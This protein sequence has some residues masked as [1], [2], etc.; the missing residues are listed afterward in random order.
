M[1]IEIHIHN[2]KSQLVPL[3]PDGNKTKFPKQTLPT[4]REVEHPIVNA[5]DK[6]LRYEIETLIQGRLQKVPVKR[7]STKTYKFDTGCLSYVT[8]VLKT[9]QQ[10]YT[11]VDKRIP[12]PPGEVIP[13]RKGVKVRPYQEEATK[14]A[15]KSQRGVLRLATG[16][17]KTFIA[18]NVLRKLNVPT[19]IFVHTIDLLD[20]FKEAGEFFLNTP[21]GSIGNGEV[22]IQQFTVCMMQTVCKAFDQK[23]VSYE[24]DPEGDYAE[25]SK[26]YSLQQ[27]MKIR[28]LVENAQAIVSDEC[29]VKG[30]PIIDGN[31]IPLPIEEVTKG[32]RV[33]SWNFANQHHEPQEVLGLL[34][35]TTNS[36][37]KIKSS[38]G[39]YETTPTHQWYVYDGIQKKIVKK[40]SSELDSENDRLLAPRKLSHTVLNN[41]S[42]QQAEFLALICCDG[43]SDSRSNSIK[44]EASKDVEYF[45]RAFASYRSLNEEAREHKERVSKRSNENSEWADTTV[46]DL[47][48]A[49]VRQQLNA[50]GIP[51]GNK[52][53]IVS[54]PKQI[55]NAPLPTV[56]QFLNTTYC[57][58]GSVQG[59]SIDLRMTSKRYVQEIQLLLMRFGIIAH[60]KEFLP[61]KWK[62][63]QE[64]NASKQYHLAICDRAS[65]ELFHQHVGFNIARKHEK[66]AQLVASYTKRSRE[67]IPAYGLLRAYLKEIGVSTS[68]LWS[69]HRIPIPSKGTVRLDMVSR[70]IVREVLRLTCLQ[71]EQ[72]SLY[73]ELLERTRYYYNKILEIEEREE[74]TEVYD[75]EVA[76][77]HTFFAGTVITSNCHHLSCKTLQ[78]LFKCAKNAFYRFGL[79]AT[80]REDGADLVIYGVTGRVVYDVTA[81]Y[82]IEH[83]PPYLVR[84]TIYYLKVKRPRGSSGNYHSRYKSDIVE[85]DVRNELIIQS[86]MRLVRKGHRVL[87]LARQIKH[88][89]LLRDMME[90]GY[91]A[92]WD[93]IKDMDSTQIKYELAT[94]AVNKKER[95]RIVSEMRRGELECLFA[96]TIA[97]EG[98]DC[99]PISAVILAGGGKSATKAFQRVGRALRLSEGKEKAVII[100]FYDQGKYF[101]KHAER[102]M[103][104]FKKEPAFRLKIQK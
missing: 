69:K 54:V 60:Y 80:L 83:N 78:T 101:K 7:F 56:A 98:L 52:H 18:W 39:I 67:S 16:A 49:Q 40:A 51:S 26:E 3:L 103:E 41:L 99:P 46:W 22:D 57:C 65:I 44:V 5:L 94:G 1:N 55:F 21:V 53:S 14:A 45:R 88:L 42:P 30:T 66:V 59:R 77:T 96:S 68:S 33:A 10:P 73:Q 61:S 95:K 35:R 6:E 48:D 62:R 25:D 86:A 104:L 63:K 13:F 19:V 24:V 81:S 32:S 76:N 97:D 43:H 89:K 87:V 50:F 93:D 34:K 31:G 27:K 12:T 74:E 15:L 2:I 58:E 85:Y 82:L 84:P 91:G 71:G 4:G 8:K 20:Q 37:I 17:G 92:E 72:S 70:D 23:Y 64:Y 90:E 28:D 36:V 11:I 75:F 38:L 100:D 79:T 29:F 102:R 9:F 47:H